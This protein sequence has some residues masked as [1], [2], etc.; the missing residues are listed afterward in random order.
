MRLWVSAH[1]LSHQVVG[2]FRRLG[3]LG[4]CLAATS[5][6]RVGAPT[7]GGVAAT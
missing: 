5:L 7:I 1:L 4:G 2:V 6:E 3:P